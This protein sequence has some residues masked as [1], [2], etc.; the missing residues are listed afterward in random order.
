MDALRPERQAAVAE[1]V[2]AVLNDDPLIGAVLRRRIRPG[3]FSALQSH[4]VIVNGHIAVFY[5]N[6]AAGV[7]IDRVR[8]GTSD[9][10]VGRQHPAAQILHMVALVDV[11]RPERRILKSHALEADIGAV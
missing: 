1:P 5:Q 9:R 7:D 8:A 11:R 10:R 2:L 4:R 3:T 6:I